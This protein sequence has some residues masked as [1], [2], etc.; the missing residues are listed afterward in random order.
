MGELFDKLLKSDESIFLNPQFLDFDY[1]PKIVPC[2]EGEQQ[3]IASHIKPLLQRRNGTNMI[4]IGSPGVGKTVTLRH[5]LDELKEDYSSEVIC[6]YI[7]CWK[8]DTSFKVISDICIQ[9][10][11]KWIHN[12]NFDDLV[13]SAAELIN[14]KSAVI[15]LD[16]VDKLQD[17]N[18]IYTLLE[19]IFRRSLILI[20]NEKDFLI[21]LDNRIRSRLQPKTLE[22]QPYKKD[23]IKQILKERIQYVFVP[24]TLQEEVLNPVIDEA[25]ERKDMRIAMALLKQAGEYAEDKSSK[26]ITIDHVKEAIGNLSEKTLEEGNEDLINIIKENNGK[27][28]ADIFKIYEEKEKKSYRTFQRKVKELKETK[29]INMKEEQGDLGKHTILE[30]LD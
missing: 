11:Y 29:K 17:Q 4:I 14:E 13:K 20:T 6:L 25:F 19:D 28:Q 1:Q 30:Y 3:E 27:P 18:I 2:R 10:N 12:K 26:K 23:Q 24:N 22:F 16:E 8:K 15:V 9:L 5:V 7:N 21:K